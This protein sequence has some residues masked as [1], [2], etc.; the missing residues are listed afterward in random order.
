MLPM[1]LVVRQC[2]CVC[3]VLCCVVL[4][5][6][7]VCMCHIGAVIKNELCLQCPCGYLHCIEAF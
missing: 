1:V 2:V 3:V 6:C 7:V 5:M 4:C